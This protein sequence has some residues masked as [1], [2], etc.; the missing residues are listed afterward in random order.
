MH[1]V[2]HPVRVGMIGVGCHARSVLLPALRGQ[3][4][5]CACTSRAETAAEVEDT[6]RLNGFNWF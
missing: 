6:Y 1:N 2:H 4:I 5:V 3:R